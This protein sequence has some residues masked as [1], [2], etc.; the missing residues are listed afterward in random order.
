MGGFSLVELMLAL[1]LGLG[2]SGVML[3][4]LMADGQ[5]GARFSQLLRERANQRRTLELI[6]GD[7]AQ[8]TD[9][10]PTPEL[11]QHA[12]SLSGRKPVLYL[13]TTAGAITYSVGSAPSA[14]WQG[15]VLMRCGPAFGLDGSI[16]VGSQSLNRVLMDSLAMHPARWLKCF[17]QPESQS[18]LG[19]D[20]GE[21][22]VQPFSGCLLS[23]QRM[24]LL[25]IVQKFGNPSRER[26]TEIE[27][28]GA[29]SVL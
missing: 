2:L 12:C 28:E 17:S 3:Q 5:N 18:E 14:I 10:S 22:S 1:C 27:I 19:I 11:E 15:Q 4:G 21:S 20:L 6:K 26:S 13:R 23:E 29:V 8:A 24:V 7:L 9:V 16:S 25:R